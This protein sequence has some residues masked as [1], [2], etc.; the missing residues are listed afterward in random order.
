MSRILSYGEW[1]DICDRYTGGDQLQDIL[2]SWK[3]DATNF[4]ETIH[5]LETYIEALEKEPVR[6][7]SV[8][9]RLRSQTGLENKKEIL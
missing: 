3:Y 9:K 7:K 6:S 1:V 8:I 4:L 2:A 5:K